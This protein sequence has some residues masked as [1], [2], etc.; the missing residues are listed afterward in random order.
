M[1]F[2]LMEDVCEVSK[3]TP[4]LSP[5]TSILDSCRTSVRCIWYRCYTARAHI[6]PYSQIPGKTVGKLRSSSVTL[7]WSFQ[8]WLD[9]VKGVA[10][11]AVRLLVSQFLKQ[12]K[13]LCVPWQITSAAMSDTQ[14]TGLRDML[15]CV[16][17]LMWKTGPALRGVEIWSI[18]AALL[19]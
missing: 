2:F 3:D 5:V 6:V 7:C 14:I 15:T 4:T 19:S 18:W 17:S 10:T 1:I 12:V 9:S 16:K 13:K 8:R 11:S